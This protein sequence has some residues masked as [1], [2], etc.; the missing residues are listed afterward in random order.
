[1]QGICS[2]THFVLDPEIIAH[3]S[4]D[5]VL[6]QAFGQWSL[7]SLVTSQPTE[8]TT[9][10]SAFSWTG[11][12]ISSVASLT[13]NADRRTE[14]D[15]NALTVVDCVCVAFNQ[16]PGRF[17]VHMRRELRRPVSSVTSSLRPNF[18]PVFDYIGPR[19]RGPFSG[20][21]VDA[22]MVDTGGDCSSLGQYK[23]YTQLLEDP[24]R[25]WEG[26]ASSQTDG[27]F[28]YSLVVSGT[29]RLRTPARGSTWFIVVGGS[30]TAHICRSSV[31]HD[32]LQSTS[33]GRQVR[34]R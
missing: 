31:H 27:V 10:L 26:C 14:S 11:Q 5:Y 1:M 12:C 34:G 33:E 9:T 32:D 7:P 2:F 21:Y 24:S 22:P 3:H 30:Y 20:A 6:Q 17:M 29:T 15:P 25:I 4:S 13:S 28:N 23:F 8:S 19:T 16:S 18:E